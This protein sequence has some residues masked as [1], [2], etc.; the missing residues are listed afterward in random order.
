MVHGNWIQADGGKCFLKGALQIWGHQPG[1]DLGREAVPAG[2]VPALGPA[3]VLPGMNM[4]F[5]SPDRSQR[6]APPARD[7]AGPRAVPVFSDARA[8]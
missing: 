6:R 4:A 1:G 5:F 2:A 3:G 7:D 8:G